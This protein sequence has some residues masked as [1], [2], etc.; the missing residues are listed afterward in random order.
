MDKE[1]QCFLIQEF[2]LINVEEIGD[3]KSPLEQHSNICC[4]MDAKSS[5]SK[6]EEKPDI[7]IVLKH[8][9]KTFTN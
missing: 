1:G 5:E 4:T 8:S 3:R 2:Q 9:P 7:Y 6:F